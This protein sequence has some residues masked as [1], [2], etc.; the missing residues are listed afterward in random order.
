M[1]PVAPKIIR[2]MAAIEISRFE[3]PKGLIS[4]LALEANVWKL[5]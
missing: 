4:K 3:A 2:Q 5:P 1:A